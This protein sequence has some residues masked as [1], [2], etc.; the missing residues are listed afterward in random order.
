MII[1]ESGQIDIGAIANHSSAG[2][3]KKPADKISSSTIISKEIPNDIKDRVNIS[4][5]DSK[6]EAMSVEA[7]EM[8]FVAPNKNLPPFGTPEIYQPVLHL[9]GKKYRIPGYPG[10]RLAPVKFN[11]DGNW[12]ILDNKANYRK[13]HFGNDKVADVAKKM[14]TCYLHTKDT[15]IDGEK[16]RIY[17]YWYYYAE[18]PLLINQHEHDWEN[19]QV[20]VK[21]DGTPKW[22]F[23]SSHF[24]NHKYEGEGK[25]YIMNR[26]GMIGF[27][28]KDVN[29]EGSHPK[30]YVA[31]NGHAMVADTKHFTFFDRC[32]KPYVFKGTMP[33]MINL[34]DP[35]AKDNPFPN[36]E[37]RYGLI[38]EEGNLNNNGLPHNWFIKVKDPITRDS[39][40][41]GAH[42]LA[43]Y[44]HEMKKEY[45]QHVRDTFGLN[46]NA[47]PQ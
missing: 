2:I 18:N 34:D 21:K 12:N 8:S 6:A 35:L 46:N 40:T 42:T 16:Y 1:R 41:E 14:G 36:L 33:T 17:Q 26:R 15:E 5:K 39:F 32:F 47:S 10:E 31:Q 11:F 28:S 20:Y 37:D 23:T 22:V 3:E 44:A 24:L 9:S 27:D 43:V 13:H 25:T 30:V 29:W 45:K 38:D 7:N 19:V 4:Q